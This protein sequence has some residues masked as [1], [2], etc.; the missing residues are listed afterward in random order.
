M[1]WIYRLWPWLAPYYTQS[2][3]LAALR[4]LTKKA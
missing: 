2:D 1:T 3:L 4:K